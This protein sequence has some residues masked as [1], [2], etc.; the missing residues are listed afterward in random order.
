MT[1]RKEWQLGASSV[2]VTKIYGVS[3]YA[4]RQYKECGV[5]NI[6]ISLAWW[7]SDGFDFIHNA[8]KIK[9]Y[10]D[11]YGV[12]IWSL[13]IPFSQVY[14]P[15]LLEK[16]KSDAFMEHA[17]QEIEAGIRIGAK[18]IVIHPSSEPNAP[19]DR[20][21]LMQTAI[22]NLTVFSN[23]CHEHGAVLAVENLPRTCLCNCS[24]E[25]LRLVKEV[26]HL[27][28]C[29]DTNHSLI[30]SN[31]EFLDDLIKNG[32]KGKIRTIH[33]SDYDFV[34]ERHWMPKEG[35]NDWEAILSKLEE[36]DFNGVFLYELSKPD[37]QKF[38]YTLERVK[39]NFEGLIMA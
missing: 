2:I 7:M 20:E 26:P 21:R 37:D 18:T 13:H 10:T 9:E 30:Q 39:E 28:I 32:M 11:R 35:V 1:N 19:E 36:L 16:E 14:H 3:E 23:Y 4:F 24:A 12:N 6:E 31:V 5:K 15:A 34:D 25:L 22:K 29:F 8:E 27:Q 33:V 17:L 38:Y